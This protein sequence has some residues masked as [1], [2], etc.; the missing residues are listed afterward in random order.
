MIS[1]KRLSLSVKL[2]LLIAVVILLL[3][4]GLMWISYRVYSDKINAVYIQQVE[5][6]AKAAGNELVP[7]YVRYFWDEINTDSFREIRAEAIQAG[8]EN[9]IRDWLISRPSWFYSER[10]PKEWE[11]YVLFE[12]TSAA[13]GS[14][15]RDMEMTLYYDYQILTDMLESF[16]EDFDISVAYLQFDEDGVTY[17]LM[18]PQ[19]NLF[20]I[21]SVEEPISEFSEYGDNEYI[22]ATIYHSSYG[23]LCS[24]TYPLDDTTYG[25]PAGT[26]GVDTDME[27]VVRSCR[28]FLVNCSFF[29]VLMTA[30]AM[31]AGMF[32]MRRIAVDPL[33]QL[34][35]AATNFADDDDN[36][37][38]DDVIRLDINSDDEI[39]DLYR[40]IRA[41][42]SRI[43][44]YTDNLMRITAE[45][46]RVNTE[47]NMAEKIQR[48][49]LPA[50]FPAFPDH[51]EFDLYASMIPAREVGG[52]F[53]DF[54]L[55]D[56]THLAVVIADV[57]D[58]GVPAA[59]FM[60]ASMILIR[61]RTIKGGTPAE[62][63]TEVNR[64]I[65]RSNHSRMFV[66]VWMGIIDL[67]TGVM[68]C[69]N[70]GHEYPFIRGADGEFRILKDK[71]GLVVGGM[72][73]TVYRDYELKL[74][75]GGAVFVYTD[76]VPE[77]NDPAAEMFG[78]NRLEASL[79]RS[80][81]DS[82]REILDRVKADV[83]VFAD[84][85]KQ[86]DD[87]TM[88]CLEYKGPAAPQHA[89]AA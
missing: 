63:M 16:M 26:V 53:Y 83:D 1:K 46:E 40:Q 8:D 17:N 89:D 70:A 28:M 21:G 22:P 2:N 31:A 29:V 85:A 56:E 42:E 27:M 49:M 25:L 23:W 71:H 73:K 41:M 5:R 51:S 34:A 52:D 75:P 33:R 45:R 58:K 35:Q 76:G 87:L 54:F 84:G 77:A 81:K 20:Y 72:E 74:E 48:D 80:P 39:G 13:D 47:L 65:W 6:A 43:V 30:A 67:T 4:T 61:Y 68:T 11:E 69:T 57:S 78:M 79:N 3:S 19:E 62:I 66:T 88:L 12:E 64:L 10:F 14:S 60:M 44:S 86:F 55:T 38:M 50:V 7:D 24:T 82:P 37:T 15:E 18:D 32:V 9:M 36:L 59:L